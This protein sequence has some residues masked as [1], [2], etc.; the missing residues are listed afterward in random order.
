MIKKYFENF[1]QKQ[2][3]SSFFSFAQINDLANEARSIS[4]HHQEIFKNIQTQ[5]DFTITESENAIK[6]IDTSISQA[7]ELNNKVTVLRDRLPGIKDRL[8]ELTKQAGISKGNAHDVKQ[9]AY[10]ILAKAE[11][12]TIDSEV[13]TIEKVERNSETMK[14]LV[15]SMQPQLDETERNY[16]ANFMRVKEEMSLVEEKYENV[17]RWQQVSFEIKFSIF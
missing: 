12:I 1:P 8:A 2:Y 4:L 17:E 16:N 9:R 7:R 10:E 5:L 11:S 14:N 6:S 13:D 3:F 15:N